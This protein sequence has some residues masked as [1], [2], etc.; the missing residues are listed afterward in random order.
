M[1]GNFM[2][3]FLILGFNSTAQQTL[4]IEQYNSYITNLRDIPSSVTRVI[5]SNNSFEPFLGT[6]TGTYDNINYEF[7]ISEV[8]ESDS[9]F[10][11]F[12]S[13]VIRFVARRGSSILADTR[14]EE[15]ESISVFLDRMSSSKKAHFMVIDNDP[16][17]SEL[18]GRF[19][20]IPENSA[21]PTVDPNP[22]NY[23]IEVVFYKVPD[24]FVVDWCPNGVTPDQFPSEV[25]INLTKQ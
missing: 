16:C 2:I 14:Q 3:I 6:W 19:K 4:S 9:G 15:N 20:L 23:K 24:L 5:D 8:S 12:E 21:Y 17:N 7:I 13:M 11:E 25:L 22:R 1:K 10:E 18:I